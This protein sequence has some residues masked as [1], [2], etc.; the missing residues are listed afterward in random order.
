MTTHDARQVHMVDPIQGGPQPI[1]QGKDAGYAVQHEVDVPA[2][3]RGWKRPR[4][5]SQRAACMRK[6]TGQ[7]TRKWY[8]LRTD[9]QAAH[10]LVAKGGDDNSI[11][12]SGFRNGIT[13]VAV[14]T[15]R[16][17][18]AWAGPM[19]AVAKGHAAGWI[20]G[21]TLKRPRFPYQTFGEPYPLHAVR[22]LHVHGDLY[23]VARPSVR[24]DAARAARVRA[25]KGKVQ[26]TRRSQRRDRRGAGGGGGAG[27]GAG[28]GAGGG[29]GG[30][31]GDGKAAGTETAPV[32][33]DAA[34]RVADV[35]LLPKAGV[36]A[37]DARAALTAL[38]DGSTSTN[39]STIWYGADADR[40]TPVRTAQTFSSQCVD[41][42]RHKP[43]AQ[44]S[45]T[46]AVAAALEWATKQ[47][48]PPRRDG[49][50]QHAYDKRKPVYVLHLVLDRPT[51][52]EEDVDELVSR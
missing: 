51:D 31:E 12:V 13:P 25:G 39:K 23:C 20:T 27:A 24:P 19:F 42:G 36:A 14:V 2:T 15:L 52:T 49:E 11:Y 26:W 34:S 28:A 21:G 48:L 35:F 43:S 33:G 47:P 30:G 44:Q 41:H 32:A 40:R 46:T 8:T 45:A 6:R 22:M 50:A 38:V 1:W 4:P 37:A 29:G 17:R 3:F 9:A 5:E 7:D 16:P 10:T 18:K